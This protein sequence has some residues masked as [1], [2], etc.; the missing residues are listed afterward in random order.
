MNCVC[1]SATQYEDGMSTMFVL[2]LL[3]LLLSSI[4]VVIVV[5]VVTN[6]F[7]SS[8][9]KVVTFCAFDFDRVDGLVV[10]NST[11]LEK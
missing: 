4:L 2:L 7:V 9:D 1:D 8:L 6:S 11:C 10:R 5:V 3:L